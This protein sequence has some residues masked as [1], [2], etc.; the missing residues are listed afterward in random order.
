MSG[1]LTKPFLGDFFDTFPSKQS[2]K[3]PPK[4]GVA[5]K[6]KAI[7]PRKGFCRNPR[8]SWVNFAEDFLD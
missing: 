7:P 2:T 1:G 4:N 6:F 8:E 5:G 3:N